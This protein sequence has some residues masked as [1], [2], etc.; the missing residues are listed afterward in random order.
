MRQTILR[1]L[2]C[3]SGIFLSVSGYGEIDIEIKDLWGDVNFKAGTTEDI[4]CSVTNPTDSDV[5]SWFIDGRQVTNENSAAFNSEDETMEQTFSLAVDYDSDG[6]SLKCSCKD[7]EDE[8]KINVFNAVVPDKV[9]IL[10]IEEGDNVILKT[11]LVLFP[12]PHAGDVLWKIASQDGQTTRLTPGDS[13]IRYKALEADISGSPA[14]NY[15]YVLEIS[16]FGVSEMNN[17]H[18]LELYH[19]GQNYTVE[20]S[21]SLIKDNGGDVT[22]DTYIVTQPPTTGLGLGVWVVL[23]VITIIVILVIIY[24]IYKRKLVKDRSQAA[25]ND[26]NDKTQYTEVKTKEDQV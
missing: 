26:K 20:F 7:K 25:Q 16:S 4:T 9:T 23:I 8:I 1:N 24:C 2:W 13:N 5:I 19:R 18:T 15:V 22:T 17:V 3:L 12:A 6:S 21:L 14:V 10:P 11:G